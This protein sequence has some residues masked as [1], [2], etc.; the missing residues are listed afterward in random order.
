MMVE[1]QDEMVTLPIAGKL[2]Y[3]EWHAIIDGFYVGYV[4]G[5]RDHDYTQEKHYWRAGFIAGDQIN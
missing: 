1:E 5:E 3:R 2:T 4:G